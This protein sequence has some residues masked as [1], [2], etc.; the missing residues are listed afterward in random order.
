VKRE[1]LYYQK[2]TQVPFTGKTLGR[3][4]GL[5]KDGKWNGPW[6]SYHK[7]GQ[8]DFKANYKDGKLHGPVV[9]YDENGQVSSK[10]TYKDGVQV[11]N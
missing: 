1:G 6:V 4:Q 11:P 5:I 8:L 9:F 3:R 7:D 2:F 10:G